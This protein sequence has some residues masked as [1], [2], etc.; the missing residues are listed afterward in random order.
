MSKRRV[1]IT[2]IGVISPNG[3]GKKNAW[4]AFSSGRS[5][6]R[7]V[8]GFDVSVFNTKIASQVVDFDPFK[9][10]LSHQEAVRMDRYV[11]FGLA[12]GKMAVEDSGLDFSKEDLE[13]AGVCLANAICG[14]KYMEGLPW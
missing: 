2:G 5:G 14:T 10:G 9:L 3:I 1:V 4:D 6:V 8:E 7:R 11:Q 12:A 13:R